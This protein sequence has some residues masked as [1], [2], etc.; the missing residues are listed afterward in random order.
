MNGG[1]IKFTKDITFSQVIFQIQVVL[2][3]MK[4]RNFLNSLKKFDY[5]AI[6]KALKKFKDL[7]Y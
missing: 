3:L 4:Q 2:Y 5:N 1:K 6:D 7:V